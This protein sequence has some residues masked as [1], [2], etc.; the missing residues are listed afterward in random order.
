MTRRVFRTATCL[1]LAACGTAAC[2]NRKD[3]PDKKT[4]G[5]HHTQLSVRVGG[6]WGK[7]YSINVFPGDYV[8]VE[9]ES[10]PAAKRPGV[11]EEAAEGLCVV[12]I[13]Q[14]Q[15]ERFEMAMK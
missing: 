1:A 6:T 11:P 9:H 10:C 3:V 5:H 13:T 15:S 8:V 12:R 14:E 4:I 2:E 7:G